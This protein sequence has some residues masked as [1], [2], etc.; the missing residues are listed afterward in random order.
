MKVQLWTFSPLLASAGC[1]CRLC[2]LV[3]PAG[4][5]CQR[6]LAEW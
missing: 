5:A 6:S 2:L 3:V 4:C 1:A